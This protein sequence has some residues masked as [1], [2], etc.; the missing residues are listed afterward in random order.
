MKSLTVVALFFS[1]AAFA[2]KNPGPVPPTN[3]NQNTNYD[4]R[5]GGGND[6]FEFETFDNHSIMVAIK[7]DMDIACDRAGLCTLSAVTS[8]DARFTTQF[9]IGVG[10]QY[11]GWN[12]GGN[13]SGTTVIVP[14][15]T[16]TD[17]NNNDP[18][19]GLSLRYTRG[20]CTQRVLVPR[21][22]YIAMNRY[23][24]GL[25]AEDGGTRRGFTPA[26]EAMIMFYSTIMK[27]ASG[28]TAGQ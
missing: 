1:L 18:Y 11:G 3:T 7:R 23:M 27:Q 20:R 16:N 26:D 22:L 21:A 8:N 17:N 15:G 19:Y 9:N 13:G 4:D 2:Q 25:M 12:N 6:E 24:Y 28:C 14:N 10:N 5:F